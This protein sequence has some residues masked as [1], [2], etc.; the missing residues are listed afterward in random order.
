MQQVWKK[1]EQHLTDIP[2]RF[3]VGIPAQKSGL[4][5]PVKCTDWRMGSPPRRQHLRENSELRGLSGDK[6][7]LSCP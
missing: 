1:S 4:S 5:V 2:G 3:I 7:H 6:R